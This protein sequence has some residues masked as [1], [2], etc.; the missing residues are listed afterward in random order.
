MNITVLHI[1]DCPNTDPLVA[2]LEDLIRDRSDISLT[3]VLVHTDEE[4]RKLG[5]HG[6][7]TILV[8]GNDPFPAPEGSIGLSCRR[9][10]CCGDGAGKATGYPTGDLLA[11]VINIVD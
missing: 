5:F 8:D 6:S 9:Y 11:E 1:E 7:P 2:E 4:G 10:Q 3:T